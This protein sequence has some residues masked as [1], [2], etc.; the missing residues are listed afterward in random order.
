[1]IGY[2]LITHQTTKKGLPVKAVLIHEGVDIKR[3]LYLAFILDRKSQKPA[4]ICSKYGGVE[5]EDVPEKDILVE[6]IEP[7][8]G[9]TDA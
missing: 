8:L 1:M 6:V 3:E 4:L 7:K 5:I 9:L 2:N